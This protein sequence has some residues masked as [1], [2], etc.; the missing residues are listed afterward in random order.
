MEDE[1]ENKIKDIGAMLGISEIPDSITDVISSFITPQN[2]QEKICPNCEQEPDV[3]KIMEFVQKYQS[4]KAS[5]E[6]DRNIVL[7]R[8]LSPYLDK[9]KKRKIQNCEKVLTILKMI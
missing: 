6:Q 2:T 7:L 3:L 1:L 5:A 9:R 4:A 8:A